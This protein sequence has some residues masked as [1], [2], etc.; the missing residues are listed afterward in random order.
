MSKGYSPAPFCVVTHVNGTAVRNLVHLVEMLRDCKD[1]FLS[2]DLAGLSSP[3]VFR[4]DNM[5]KATDNILSDE[6]I[7][8]QYSDNLEKVRHPAKAR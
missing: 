1:E 2:I 4:R 3:L 6:G 7:R 5:A 8:K